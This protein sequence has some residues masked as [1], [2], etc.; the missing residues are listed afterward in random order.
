MA[1]AIILWNMAAFCTLILASQLP[2]EAQPLHVL[3]SGAKIARHA[4]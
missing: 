1:I 3:V 4:N 2:L